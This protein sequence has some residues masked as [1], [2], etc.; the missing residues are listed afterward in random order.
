MPVTRVPIVPDLRPLHPSPRL[1]PFLIRKLP[2]PMA[3]DLADLLAFEWNACWL[4]LVRAGRDRLSAVPDGVWCF[5]I[6]RT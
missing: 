5:A 1:A 3:A 4:G 2:F 6:W